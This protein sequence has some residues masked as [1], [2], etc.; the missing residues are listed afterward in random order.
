MAAKFKGILATP[1]PEKPGVSPSPAPFP[2]K[3]F[4]NYLFSQLFF[5]YY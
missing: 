3:L 2:K 5:Y 4:A 1:V